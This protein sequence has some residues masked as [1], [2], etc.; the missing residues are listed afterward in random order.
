MSRNI[1]NN[2]TRLR[3]L[4]AVGG[5]VVAVLLFGLLTCVLYKQLLK[6]GGT[7]EDFKAFI[8]SFG[9]TGW[10]V[11][12]GIQILQVLIALI[13]GELVEIGMG[14][15]FGAVQGTILCLAGV[16]IASTAVFL[17]TRR[18]GVRFL[19]LFFPMEKFDNLWFMKS[20]K[21]LEGI[22]F[23]LFFIPGTP[24]DLLTYFVGLTR[25]KLSD[26]LVISTIARIPSVVSS[27]IGGNLISNGNFVAA[28]I[29]FTVTALVSLGGILLYKWILSKKQ[30]R[31]GEQDL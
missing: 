8:D 10:L 19:E 11:G 16:L 26:F 17:L 31:K 28:A 4:L 15:A 1:G 9:F 23:L 7:P 6:I 27:T 18:F 21:R 25:M 12:L 22:V 2:Q 5:L 13:P 29:L 24:K 3:R 14:C 30:R 20:E